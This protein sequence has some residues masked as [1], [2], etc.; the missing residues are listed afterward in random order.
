[1]GEEL[2]VCHMFL[3]E[4]LIVYH[5]F[6]WHQHFAVLVS[7][8]CAKCEVNSLGRVASLAQVAVEY[9]TFFKPDSRVAGVCQQPVH[10]CL[11][12]TSKD[13]SSMV[14]SI[15]QIRT[16]CAWFKV[17]LKRKICESI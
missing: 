2:I 12:P 7:V 3:G 16:G 10:L 4:E 5:M 13:V 14:G 1:M 11:E 9:S 8:D 17:D 15:G 6:L